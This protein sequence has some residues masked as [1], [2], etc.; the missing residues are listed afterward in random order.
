MSTHLAPRRTWSVSARQPVPAPGPARQRPVVHRT[1]PR[2]ALALGVALGSL[3]SLL[4]VALLWSTV[5]ALDV[6]AWAGAGERGTVVAPGP[7]P[8]PRPLPSLP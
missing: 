6:G 4:V 3:A 7:L 5:Q 1:H 8:S 2:T